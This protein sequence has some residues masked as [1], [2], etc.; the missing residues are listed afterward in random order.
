MTT[1][2][3]LMWDL[4]ELRVVQSDNISKKTVL[5]LTVWQRSELRRPYRYLRTRR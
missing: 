3:L 2:Y 4:A 1:K 5:L